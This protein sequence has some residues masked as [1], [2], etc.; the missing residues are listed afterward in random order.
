M[1]PTI[2]RPIQII[3]Y[4]LYR[5]LDIYTN[6]PKQ[7]CDLSYMKGSWNMYF[8]LKKIPDPARIYSSC[9]LKS[10]NKMLTLIRIFLNQKLA[11]VIT[12]QTY[13]YTYQHYHMKYLFENIYVTILLNLQ[14]ILWSNYS[15]RRIDIP[16]YE[17]V[18]YLMFVIDSFPA[19]QLN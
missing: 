16:D 19:Q 8:Y 7:L 12:Y 11:L 1:R 4:T 14:L 3:G 13:T 5:W 15:Y 9:E 10:D 6:S 17:P 18:K 2:M